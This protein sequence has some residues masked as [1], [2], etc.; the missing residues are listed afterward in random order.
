MASI[1]VFVVESTDES[2]KGLLNDAISS[3]E[4]EFGGG[5]I[6]TDAKIVQVDRDNVA[7]S[8]QNGKF[9]PNLG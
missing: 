7:A 3:A 6:S 9:I 5:V 2:I 8:Y 4:R 1:L